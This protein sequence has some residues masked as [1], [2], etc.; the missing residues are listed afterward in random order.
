MNLKY[1]SIAA[2]MAVAALLIFSG[3]Y[4]SQVSASYTPANPVIASWDV[5][6]DIP[7]NM[8]VNGSFDFVKDTSS[9][10]GANIQDTTPSQNDALLWSVTFPDTAPHTLYVRYSAASNQGI[11][12]VSIDGLNQSTIDSYS[13]TTT[14]NVIKSITITP[15][16]IGKNVMQFWVASKNPSSA[17]Y[18]F[19]LNEWWI[20]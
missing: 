4:F 6:T 1:C 3:V 5:V 16:R 18:G 19:L 7:K 20:I 2:V 9:L 17:A 11:V 15:A 8:S 14:P 13:A 12:T 10:L